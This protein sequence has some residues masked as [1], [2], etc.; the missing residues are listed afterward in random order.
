VLKDKSI[1]VKSFRRND[2]RIR[3]R[4]ASKY[5]RRKEERV[6]NILNK[7]SKDIALNAI[8]IGQAIIFEDPKSRSEEVTILGEMKIECF[9]QPKR[10][11]NHPE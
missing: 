8:K 4:I 7:I 1:I 5:G 9:H 10:K 2:V 11:Q 6:K 3:M